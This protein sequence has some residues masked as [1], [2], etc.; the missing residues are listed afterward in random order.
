MQCEW[1][2]FLYL[3]HF[4]FNCPGYREQQLASFNFL[5][6]SLGANLLLPPYTSVTP[7]V[8][9][10]TPFSFYLGGGL[11]LVPE[12]PYSSLEYILSKLLNFPV[13]SHM[14][15]NMNLS[16]RALRLEYPH[17]RCSQL[18]C[19]IEIWSSERMVATDPHCEEVVGQGGHP[20]LGPLCLAHLPPLQPPK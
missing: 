7:S 6:F 11:T 2:G 15:S 1:E 16:I 4:T 8:V 3:F 18:L 19:W 13:K 5:Q 12:L 9:L 10:S 17:F 20:K 14:T